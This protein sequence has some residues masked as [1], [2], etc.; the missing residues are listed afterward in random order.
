MKVRLVLSLLLG[1]FA[2]LTIADRFALLELLVIRAGVPMLFAL[3][4]A[5][6]IIGIGCIVR[7]SR[8]SDPAL[9]FLIGLPMFGALLFL[10]GLLNVSA[11]TIWPLIALLGIA[12]VVLILAGWKQQPDVPTSSVSLI[13]VLIVLVCGIVTALAPPTSIGEIANTLAVPRAWALEGRA[14]DLPLLAHSYFP[15][16]IESADVAPIAILG[17]L[18]GGV[19]SHLLHLFAAIAAGLLIY[20]CTESWFL[21][22]AIVTTPAL[23]IVAGWSLGDWPVVGLFVATFIALEHDDI[24]TASAATAA[25]LLA[26]YV[27]V[28]FAIVAWIL[29]RRRPHWIALLG[30][31]FFVRNLI[32][33]WNPVA[34]FFQEGA[35]AMSGFRTLAL[36]DYVFHSD[37]IPESIGVALLA[38]PFFATGAIA[39]A[40]ALLGLALFFL[41]P[42]A[43]VLVP[44]LVLPA[45]T[46]KHALQKKLVAA[47]VAIAIVAQTL[48]V[49]WFT[50]RSE[51]F[52]L[53]TASTSTDAYLRK[54]SATYASVAWLNETLP[55]NSRTL[56]IGIGETYWF[57]KRVRGGADSDAKRISNYLDLPA[58]EA[59]RERLRRDGI[60]HVA[61]LANEKHPPLEASAQKMLAQTLDHYAASV[62]TR[63]NATLFTIR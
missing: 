33:T 2:L 59:V 24:R 55:A 58:A 40:G 46:T 28:P 10:V 50:A 51:S 44:F 34:P 37:Y 30:L 39:I 35:P 5:I 12:G 16:G 17:A 1:L 32:L 23:A 43:R 26:S 11:W 62:T 61:I 29:K 36:A 27:F 42:S 18:Q 60:T 22:A 14:I 9:D 8:E 7:G 63:G 54:Q 31:L 6:A 41:A 38:L 53:L 25:G 4:Q 45:M 3:A 20:R 49:A 19:A 13:A 48:L 52:S 15:L 47:L 21:T 56:V 57:T